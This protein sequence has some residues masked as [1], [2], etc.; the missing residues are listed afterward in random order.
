VA[1]TDMLGRILPLKACGVKGKDYNRL[2]YGCGDQI[3]RNCSFFL[4]LR[5]K[6]STGSR[7]H[8]AGAQIRVG[9]SAGQVCVLEAE[10]DV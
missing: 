6:N 10:K 8:Q 5:V 3:S 1:E 9:N 4:Q 7:E 2:W